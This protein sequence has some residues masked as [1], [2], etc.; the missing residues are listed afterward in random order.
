MKKLSILVLLSLF[1]YITVAQDFNNVKITPIKAAGNVYMLKGAGGNIGVL[2]SDNG[3]VLIDDQFAPLAERIEAAMKT[4]KDKPL[5][6]I[7]NTHFHGDHTGSNNFFSEKAP[8][9]AHQNVR[10]RL[11]DKEPAE[12]VALP[13]VTYQQSMTIYFANEEI[14]LTHY[15]HGHTDGDTAVYFKK[16]NVLHTGDLFFELGFPYI[17]LK[18]GGSVKGYLAAVEKML[19]I[20]PDDVVIIPG[21]GKLT[22]KKRYQ[23]F[24]KMIAFSIKHVTELLQQGKSEQAIIKLGL[25]DKYKSW[26]WQFINEEKWLKTLVKDLKS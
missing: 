25:G 10:A 4:I 2:A 8:I 5:K 3:L 6:Y 13:V 26:S 22:D 19:A 23:A 18:H 12:Q 17:D 21:H 14:Q 24:A 7:I 15:A 20:I 9:Y 16:A 1:S 11:M